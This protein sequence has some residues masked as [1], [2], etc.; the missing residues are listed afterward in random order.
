MLKFKRGAFISL[1]PI[2]PH[3]SKSWTLT[4][5]NHA[6]GDPSSLLSY[7]TFL[8]DCGLIFCTVHEMPV[9]APN[10]FFWANHWDG[11]EEK[12]VAYAR[13]LRN[14]MLE[15]GG[16]EDTE[17]DMDDKKRYKELIRGKKTEEKIS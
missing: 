8:L 14:I 2:K 9:F 5:Q 16:F 13:A 10:D 1:R 7:I 11:K 17:C 6:H 3:Y 15:Q 4:G 12:W